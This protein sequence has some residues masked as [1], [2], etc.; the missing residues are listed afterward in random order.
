MAVDRS[1][2]RTCSQ[3]SF[4]RRNRN[5]RSKPAYQYHLDPASIEFHTGTGTGIDTNSGG[6]TDA[7]AEAVV[8]GTSSTTDADADANADVVIDGQVPKQEDAGAGRSGRGSVIQTLKNMFTAGKSKDDDSTDGESSSDPYVRGPGPSLTANLINDAPVTSS[9]STERLNL[10]IHLHDN[11]V[12]RI[13]ITEEY[14][15]PGDNDNSA[16]S[17]YSRPYASARWTSDDLILN[18]EE[19]K[20]AS[21]VFTIDQSTNEGK[22][23][24]E[25]LTGSLDLDDI[26][27]DNYVGFRFGDNNNSDEK[28]TDSS[29]LFL[30]QFQP[31]AFHLWRDSCKNSGT[32][33]DANYGLP[34]VSIN[35]DNLMH[36]EVRRLKE[37]EMEKLRQ[38]E[39]MEEN[40]NENGNSDEV[41]DPISTGDNDE[42]EE[43]EE[44]DRHGGKEIVGY[45]EDGLAIYADGTR[46]ERKD[47]EPVDL[48]A[49]SIA[50]EKRRSLMDESEGGFHFDT[51]GMWEEKFGSHTD[52]KPYGPMSVGADITFPASTHLFGLPEHAS[53][54]QL[55][56]TTGMGAHYKEPYRLYNLDVFEYE[57][58]ET[59]ALYGEVPLIVSQSKTSGTVGVFWFNPTETF[60]DVENPNDTKGT[61]TH[62]ISESCIIDLFLLPG[63]NPKSLYQQ[64]ATLTGRMPLPPMWSLGYHQC[65][66]NYRDEEDVYQ[67]HGKFEEL[68][69]PYDVLWLDI[70]HTNGK[71]YF[72]W[73]KNLF[74]NPI[75]MQEK[76]KSQGRNMV[77]IIDPHI[78]RDNQ[79]YIHKK[80]TAKGLYIK[81][82]SG[83]SDYDGW[84]W[85][86][87]SSYL[88][89]TNEK[90]RNWWAEQFSYDQYEG[91]T[92]SL[93][94]WND[95]NEPSVFNGPEVSMQKDLRNLDGIEHREWHNL[96]GILFQR[97]TAEGLT[98]R[99]PGENV[100]PFVLSRSF[101]AGR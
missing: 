24:L 89:F 63:P 38:Q 13:R 87:S 76:L 10:A 50:E 41:E 70:E 101:F 58:D 77:T 42:K 81:D 54:T 8:G 44:E 33:V 61:K 51:D 79:Y 69:Y 39:A 97:A 26:N 30:I 65:R 73:D 4:C 74:P 62:W 98:R 47:D 95:M 19:M 21:D 36:F 11:G 18:H 43:E 55:K 82:K 68:D 2:F 20:L 59:M 5:G 35:S 96:Y 46:E 37:E 67:V 12:A 72:T 71:R 25:K 91:S 31:F 83:E 1:K 49:D 40:S 6:S 64:Y 93:F 9:G 16:G 84:C 22:A 53:S 66:W 3:T 99:N 56:G 75:P 34:A 57:L 27:I 29:S 7:A 100:R 17:A 86:G 92:P 94:T 85:P 90:V 78:K 60:E 28:C 14:D 45:W 15:T 80:A 23:L 32:V 48:D 52:S 88:D